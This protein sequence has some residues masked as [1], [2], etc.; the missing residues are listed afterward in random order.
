MTAGWAG[1][2]RANRS[3]RVAG[4]GM[5]GGSRWKGAS[6]GYHS[7]AVPR[8]KPSVVGQARTL[9][10]GSGQARTLALRPKPPAFPS[11]RPNPAIFTPFALRIRMGLVMD[12]PPDLAP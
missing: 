3:A 5:A 6:F 1:S 7:D 4:G 11:C 10:E 8:S 9:A 12:A 2:A